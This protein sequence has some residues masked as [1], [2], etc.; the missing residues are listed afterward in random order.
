M[1]FL[2]IPDA[3]LWNDL[4]QLVRN[5]AR[6]SKHSDPCVGVDRETLNGKQDRRSIQ[7]LG[8]L[9]SDTDV[10]NGSKLLQGL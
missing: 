4:L 6:A 7:R 5:E 3:P 9:Y 8:V 1:V 2:L 10:E